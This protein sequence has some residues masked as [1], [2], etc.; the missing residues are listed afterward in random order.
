MPHLSGSGGSNTASYSITIAPSYNGAF[1]F[2]TVKDRL[3]V[4]GP[5]SFSSTSL[6]TVDLVCNRAA[7]T[8]LTAESITTTTTLTSTGASFDSL[9]ATSCTIG[10]GAVAALT[11]TS[12]TVGAGTVT[13]TLT[14]VGGL[15]T[16][17]LRPRASASTDLA[18]TTTGAV[19][20]AGNRINFAGAAVGNLQHTGGTFTLQASGQT[21]LYGNGSTQ[22]VGVRTSSPAYTLDVSGSAGITGTLVAGSLSSP[23]LD[24][25]VPVGCVQMYGGSSS[26]TGWLLCDGSSVSKAGYPALYAVIGGTFGETTTQFVLPDMRGRSPLGAGTG[27]GLTARAAGAS[28]GTETHTLTI[29]QMPS[30]NHGGTTGIGGGSHA[31]GVPYN[32]STAGQNQYA[33]ESNSGSIIDGSYNTNSTNIDHTHSIASEGGG[34]SHNIMH[35]WL[36]LNFI[37]KT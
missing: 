11:A 30:H 7:F 24:M 35:P 5:A 26:P 19:N 25:L 27:S 3:I 34:Q 17:A 1:G 4:E 31:H 33:Q 22:R 32:N 15:S 2:V 6:T 9:T 16:D 21:L 13:G 14:T 23:T 18:V 20:L 29:A 36:C 8:S 12:C 37:I 28:G 10:T